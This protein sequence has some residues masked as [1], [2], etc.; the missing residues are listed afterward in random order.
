MVSPSA[1]AKS[2]MPP[3]SSS[4]LEAEFRALLVDLLRY[5]SPLVVTSH[6]PASCRILVAVPVPAL[7]AAVGV[8]DFDGAAAGNV[9]TG[10]V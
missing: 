4:T 3:L 8:G 1:V 6:N 10:P 5:N 9:G 2:S 7:N